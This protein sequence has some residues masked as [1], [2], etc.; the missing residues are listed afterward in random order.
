MRC[1]LSCDKLLEVELDCLPTGLKFKFSAFLSCEKATKC[2][3]FQHPRCTD[4]KVGIFRIRTI[5]LD[6]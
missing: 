1:N 2:M 4:F 3:K 5:F 6:L